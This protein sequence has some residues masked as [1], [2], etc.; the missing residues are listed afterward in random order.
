MKLTLSLVILL[1]AAPSAW[2]QDCVDYGAYL[3]VVS[4][5]PLDGSARQAVVDG[6]VALVASGDAGL[7]VV[8]L[9]DPDRPRPIAQDTQ[10]GTA[11]WLAH[12]AGH[13]YVADNTAGLHVYDITDPT[14][15]VHRAELPLPGSGHDL[16]VRPPHLLVA[17]GHAGLLVLDLTDP[18][19]PII[20][21]SVDTPG[22]ARGVA[23][24]AEVAVVADDAQGLAVIDIGQPHQPR[25]VGQ[26]ETEGVGY[27]VAL[28]GDLAYLAA[29]TAGLEVIDITRR[30]SPKAV[31]RL[32]LPGVA[33]KLVLRDDGLLLAAAGGLTVVDLAEPREPRVVGRA[34]TTDGPIAVTLLDSQRA[35]VT[36]SSG[37]LDVAAI[38]PPISPPRLA[39]L[40]LDG[41]TLGLATSGLLTLVGAD[42]LH[43]LDTRDP[44]APQLL[45]TLPFTGNTSRLAMGADLAYLTTAG[46][47]GARLLIADIAAPGSPTWLSSLILD[48]FISPVLP[49]G[50]VVY[51]ADFFHGGL[52]AVDVSDPTR[53]GLASTRTTPPFAQHLLRVDDHLLVG[54]GAFGGATIQT[55]DLA[56]PLAP[57][58]A[59]ELPLN[60][61]GVRGL[62]ADGT[63]LVA[64][65]QFQGGHG[66]LLVL[67]AT[68]P[69]QLTLRAALPLEAN[70]QGLAVHDGLAYVAT[71]QG[72]VLVIDLAEPGAPQPVGQT[73]LASGAVGLVPGGGVMYAA[74]TEAGLAVLPRHC[75]GSVGIEDPSDE[76]DA[77]PAPTAL[78]MSAHPNPFNP[79]VTLSFELPTAGLVDL[80]LHDVAGRHVAT[81]V[82]G[83]RRAGAQT[84]I[85]EGR[86]EAGRPLPSG[87]YLAR[88]VTHAG[89][90][91]LGVTLVR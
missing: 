56:D 28:V 64:L 13:V 48:A 26:A 58:W 57:A 33:R 41:V 66:E 9:S 59:A 50:D 61:Q 45:A 29:W 20:V 52:F 10:C 77:P 16:L 90:R 27:A 5:T 75:G 71:A 76:P 91:S 14:R 3:R 54:T 47:G 1:I 24:G 46:D 7:F 84:V 37:G 6:E 87:R 8:D 79:R 36:A 35:L 17:A 86:D 43:L 21:G 30:E 4:N 15:P 78:T 12:H 74:A 40:P 55:F 31:T 85:W 25:L 70:L 38:D 67:D 81:L 19:A 88:L 11:M 80:S 51:L 42:D 60:A 53:P 2:A 89:H 22:I 32:P 18:V 62:A 34:A 63:D 39:E 83:H 44:A 69:T 23:A 65:V 82:H 73:F 68:D 49:Y 72:L